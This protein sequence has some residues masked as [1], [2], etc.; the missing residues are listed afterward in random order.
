MGNSPARNKVYLDLEDDIVRFESGAADPFLF[1][2]VGQLTQS[3]PKSWAPKGGK[4]LRDAARRGDLARVKE[5]VET[6]HVKVDAMSK[7]TGFTPLQLA[8]FHGHFAIVEYLVAK[9]AN[10]NAANHWNVTPL[11]W[12]AMMG[13]TDIVKYLM[14]QDGIDAWRKT[15][16]QRT[17]LSRASIEGHLFVVMAIIEGDRELQEHPEKRQERIDAWNGLHQSPLYQAAWKGHFDVVQYLEVSK[18]FTSSSTV[19]CLTPL[20][21]CARCRKRVQM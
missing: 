18:L 19:C 9:G 7:L 5:A 3:V 20:L 21:P 4:A 10:I 14:Q 8:C 12:S 16:S 1:G 2:L 11:F 6:H 17:A 15:G 13:H